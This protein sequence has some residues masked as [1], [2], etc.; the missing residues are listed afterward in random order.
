MIW[1]M[2]LGLLACAYYW[3][4]YFPCAWRDG[5]NREINDIKAYADYL[6]E[7]HGR[8]LG[9]S[10]SDEPRRSEDVQDAG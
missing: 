7:S 5:S 1:F 6:K 3:L 10:Q 8:R 4:V 2:G 9:A